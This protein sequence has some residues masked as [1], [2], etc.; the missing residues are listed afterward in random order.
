MVVHLDRIGTTSEPSVHSWRPR[1]CTLYAL[2][3]GAGFDDRAYVL[4]AEPGQRV[5]PTFPLALVSGDGEARE[6]GM[7]GIGDFTGRTQVLGEQHL[8]LHAP[9]APSGEASLVTRV[10][11]VFDK[12]SGALVV[13]EAHGRDASSGTPL[14]TSTMHMFVV[15]EGGFGGARGPARRTNAWPARPPDAVGTFATSAVHSLWYRHAGN[16]SHAIHVDRD[17]ARAA[18]FATA[19]LTGQNSLGVACR[20]V[21]HAACGGDAAPVRSIGGRFARPAYSGDVLI[22]EMWALDGPS[23]AEPDA[24]TTATRRV[25]FRVVNQEG[26][27]VVDDG[28]CDLAT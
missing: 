8:V 12:G 27:V 4:D 19:I 24:G 2:A 14:F 28:A 15:G 11:D 25:L 20:A 21:V 3:V 26:T 16:D 10:A 6:D 13:L 9:I 23:G 22:T 1:D 7:L 17:A 5:Y 18:G